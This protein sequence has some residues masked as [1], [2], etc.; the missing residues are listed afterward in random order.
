MYV[1]YYS[2][3]NWPQ[4]PFTLKI[5]QK[6]K[7]FVNISVVINSF[8]LD[9]G[10]NESHVNFVLCSASRYSLFTSLQFHDSFCTTKFTKLNV[11]KMQCNKVFLISA[12]Y[13]NYCGALALCSMPVVF[14]GFDWYCSLFCFSERPPFPCGKTSSTTLQCSLHADD[15]F[16][17]YEAIVNMCTIPATVTLDVSQ[18]DIQFNYSE[19]L[20]RGTKPRKI[21]R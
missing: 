13:N 18:P 15:K 8:F 21:G 20:Y 19:V 6:K 12:N 4:H 5:H 16:V 17:F 9:Y 7:W 3:V 2:W 1:N 11:T 14:N 10:H